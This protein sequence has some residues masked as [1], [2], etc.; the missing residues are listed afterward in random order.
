METKINFRW[1]S[2]P[3]LLALSSLLSR[4]LGVFRDHLLAK[5]FGATL[6]TGIYNLDSYYAAFRIPDLLYNLIIFGALSASFIPIFAQYKKKG[7]WKNAWEFASSMLHLMLIAMGV[8]AGV[9]Y[10]FAPYLAKLVAAG[11]PPEKMEL[12][13]YLMRIMLISPL[14]FGFSAILTSIQDSMNCFF[15]RS[16]GPLF[17]NLGI[18]AGIVFFGQQFGVIG[19]TWGVVFGAALQW[20]VQLPSLRQTRFRHF[21]IL[22]IFRPDTRKAFRLMIPRL[23]GLSLS[24]IALVANTL[25]ASFLTT[26]SLTIFYL[27]DNLQSLPVGV[28]GIS[29]A[30][31]SFATLSELAAEK[32]QSY[33]A[34]ELA[35]VIHQ[36]LF[37]IIPAT[38]GMIL[39][40]QEIIQLILRSGQFNAQDAMLTAQVLFFLL[41]SLFAQSLIPVLGRAFFAHHDTKTPLWIGLVSFTVNIFSSYLLAIVYSFGIIGI[42]IAYTLDNFTKFIL[43]AFLLHKKIRHPFLY[44]KRLALIIT[45]SALMGGLLFVL[46][47]LTPFINASR[48]VLAASVGVYSMVGVVIYFWICKI[49]RIPEVAILLKRFS[50]N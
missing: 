5:T 13:I 22:G 4:L 23:L 24:Q 8:L 37:L 28:I 10:I 21:W 25:I 17:Y 31:A 15:F 6:G 11:F 36:I 2:P 12:T 35:R 20:I 46:K 38:V 40:R 33:F 14:L 41:L 42:A 9:A 30:I 27:A 43:M 49:F 44:G 19:V 50:R 47:T 26:G 29:F 32:N 39:L 45:A 48:S 18:I 1:L 3:L 16:I 34:Q 7:D